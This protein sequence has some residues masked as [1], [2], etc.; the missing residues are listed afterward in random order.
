M[1]RSYLIFALV[2]ATSLLAQVG[3]MLYLLG[4]HDAE[5]SNDINL[6]GKQRTLS[7]R[8]AFDLNHLLVEDDGAFARIRSD[9]VE[10][11]EQMDANH[12]HLMGELTGRSEELRRTYLEPP[13][14]LDA[15]VRDFIKITAII[16]QRAKARHAIDPNDPQVEYIN[17]LAG[18]TLQETLNV[19]VFQYQ[20]EAERAGKKTQDIILAI[21]VLIVLSLSFGVILFI[22]IMRQVSATEKALSVNRYVFEHSPDGIITAGQDA[23]I[24]SANHATRDIL[25]CETGVLLGKHLFSLTNDFDDYPAMEVEAVS[26]ALQNKGAWRDEIQSTSEHAAD[27]MIGIRAVYSDKGEIT[28][29]VALLTDISEQKRAEERFRSMS[30]HDGLTGLHNRAALLESL[31]HEIHVARREKTSFAFFMLD[32]DGFKQVN[33]TYG[34]KAGDEVLRQ[35]AQRLKSTVRESDIVARLGGDEFAIIQRNVDIPTDIQALAGKLITSIS[36]PVKWDGEPLT[37]GCSIGVSIYPL[38]STDTGELTHMADQAMYS[39]KQSGKN[40]YALYPQESDS[41][42]GPAVA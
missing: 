28:N 37:V 2:F 36:S 18:G 4:T 30:L 21:A 9:L 34:H 38:H 23:T 33:D 7:Q 27:F 20:K 3:A 6:A 13:F 26:T 25:N 35:V 32:L 15:K 5:L 16:T 31:D 10:S 39:I 42:A 19:A 12:A 17:E 40:D 41:Q 29:Y 8:I 24:T 1:K 11:L 14:L 22:I